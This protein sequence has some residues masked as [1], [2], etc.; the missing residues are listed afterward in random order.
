[1][2]ASSPGIRT[3]R[4]RVRLVSSI[5]SAAGSNKNPV[6]RREFLTGAG[7]V[8][9]IFSSSQ[10]FAWFMDGA[11]LDRAEPGVGLTVSGAPREVSLHFNLGVVATLSSVQVIT[12][13][14]A[15]NT[16]RSTR[17]RR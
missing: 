17:F 16:P 13:N 11:F 6:D 5:K 9:S 15:A 12:S 7:S 3:P 8:A 1:M 10:A 4:A 14:R 2:V